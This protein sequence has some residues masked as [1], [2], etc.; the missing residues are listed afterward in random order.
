VELLVL[1][2]VLALAFANG[3]NDVPKGI[4]TLTGAG[5]ARPRTALLWGI[6]TTAVGCLLSL[7]FSKKMTALFSNGIVSA[8]PTPAFAAAVLIGTVAWVALATLRT[9]PV[10]TTHAL[11]GALLGAGTLFA[12]GSV[13]WDTLLVKV[14]EPLLISVLVAYV[15]SVLLALVARGIAKLAK[16]PEADALTDDP[17]AAPEVTTPEVT[18]PAVVAPRASDRVLAV[19]HW[20]TSGLTGL[21]RGLNDTPKIVAVGAFALL[22]GVTPTM[23]AIGVAAAM[24]LGGYLVGARLV[25]RLGTGVVR[26]SH[27]EGFTANLTTAVLVGLGA[28]QGLPMST[29]HVSVGAIAGSAGVDAGRISGRT[30]R[31]FA[32]AWLVTPPFAAAVAALAYLALR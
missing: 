11:T 30:V 21:A 16:V 4:A 23:V 13:H 7:Q 28:F 6:A 15:V 17:A 18:T 24:A 2:L 25:T 26:M 22:S 14:V 5:V 12:A 20:L 27:T 9:L 29:T 8:R 10:S 19:A 1:V 32:I 3:A 31:D